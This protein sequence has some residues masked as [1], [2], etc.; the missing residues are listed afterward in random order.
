MVCGGK[1]S[2]EHI[3][4]VMAAPAYRTLAEIEAEANAVL[5]ECNEH[6]DT[7]ELLLR[8]LGGPTWICMQIYAKSY[9]RNAPRDGDC[10][11]VGALGC[12]VTTVALILS[13]ACAELGREMQDQTVTPGEQRMQSSLAA[14]SK[15]SHHI[16]VSQVK[17][18]RN[19]CVDLV[20][21]MRWSRT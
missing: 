12:V 9:P 8:G 19:S 11:R 6:I 21:Q 7:P 1:S 17:C 2:I 5:A 14:L 20:L 16:R 10:L 18:G 3:L 13:R 15:A 4:K